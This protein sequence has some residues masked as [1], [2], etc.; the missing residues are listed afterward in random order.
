M[1][2]RRLFHTASSRTNFSPF[3]P[4]YLELFDELLECAPSPFVVVVVVPLE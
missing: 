3:L 1:Q 4:L 2:A